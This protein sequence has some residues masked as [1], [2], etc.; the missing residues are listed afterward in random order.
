MSIKDDDNLDKIEDSFVRKVDESQV[1]K[2]KAGFMD[3][4]NKKN[5]EYVVKK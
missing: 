5:K 1:K 2:K 4:V 3:K